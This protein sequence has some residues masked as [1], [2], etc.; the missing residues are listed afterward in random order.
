MAVLDPVQP[1]SAHGTSQSALLW[2]ILCYTR[3]YRSQ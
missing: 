1:T 3:A 2:T